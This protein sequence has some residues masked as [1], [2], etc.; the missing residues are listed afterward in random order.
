MSGWPSWWCEPS[1]SRPLAGPLLLLLLLLLLDFLL[2]LALARLVPHFNIDWTSYTPLFWQPLTQCCA[3][4][5]PG[6]R[7]PDPWAKIFQNRTRNRQNISVSS[8]TGTE[9]AK[10]SRSV[11]KPELFWHVSSHLKN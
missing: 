10:G 9:T 4:V 6:T 3:R 8:R 11:S 2:A 5:L 1:N 7:E